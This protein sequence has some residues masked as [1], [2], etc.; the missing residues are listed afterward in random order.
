MARHDLQ[1]THAVTAFA[2]PRSALTRRAALALAA[3][4]ALAGCVSTPPAATGDIHVMTSGGFTA[5]YNE[6]RPGFERSTGR[7][8]KTAYG[9]SMGNASDS[10]PSRLGRNEPADVVILARPALDALVAQGKVVAG[11]QVD[12]VRSSIGF[13]VRKGAPKPDIGTVDALKRTLLAAPSIA[14]SA[15]ASGTYYET[16]L[17][18]TLGIE[19]QVKPK[20]KR[21]LS[22]RV[23]TVVARGDAALGLQQ[24]SELLP[25]EGI[26]YIGPLPA[27][28]QRVTVFSAGVATASKQPEAAR[29]LIRYL[30]APA[31]A[32]TIAK[33][34]L[35][36]MSAR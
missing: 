13:A 4:F 16:E 28:V 26:D 5:A 29:Q 18:K 8:V 35:E 17:L 20:S 19:D 3:S 7:S 22:E 12:L 1:E 15:S 14:Y 32:P 23:G 10:I 34:G 11:S 36:P 31:A 2:F 21:I 27:E 24:V 6:L 33:T 25:I 9:A 30:N